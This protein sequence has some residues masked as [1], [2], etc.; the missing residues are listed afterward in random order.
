MRKKPKIEP[1]TPAELASI[2]RRLYGAKGWRSKLA[3]ALGVPASTT[4]RWA[5]GQ[6]PVSNP[7][8]IAIRALLAQHK[9]QRTMQ[10]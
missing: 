8:A 3:A 2:G 5:R 4:W 6:F 9:M 1:L 7:A 10:G